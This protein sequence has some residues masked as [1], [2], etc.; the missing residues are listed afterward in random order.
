M[1]NRSQPDDHEKG[2]RP[3]GVGTLAYSIAPSPFYFLVAVGAAGGGAVAGAG[4][5]GIGLVGAGAVVAPPP[6]AGVSGTGE[7]VT[8]AGA[9][10][11]GA[12]ENVFSRTDF[13]APVCVDIT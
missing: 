13:G 6:V 7:F 9:A 3:R 1:M 10:G 4:L 12:F 11:A 5:S 8:G 2:F